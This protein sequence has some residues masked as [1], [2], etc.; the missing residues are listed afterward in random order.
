MAE[1]YT[2]TIFE[3]LSLILA[4]FACVVG[5][6]TML[7]PFFSEKKIPVESLYWFLFA[8]VAVLF[9]Y[10]KEITFMDLKIALQG[11]TDATKGLE[12][13]K[14][15]LEHAKEMIDPTRV[16]LIRGYQSYLRG[17]SEKERLEKVQL[18]TSLYSRCLRLT[19]EN[20]K[21]ML[22]REGYY[23]GKLDNEFT[24]EYYQAVC[25]FQRD[26]GLN[27]DGIFGYQSYRNLMDKTIS[28]SGYSGKSASH[29]NS[30]ENPYT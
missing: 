21:T 4:A 11:I 23:K 29:A 10:V 12:E 7:V 6:G 28:S 14:M 9:P 1:K 17:L 3:K 5:L 15:S 13:A 8:L 27:P 30:R 16:E 25:E 24:P 18:M 20:I 19:I 2:R 26:T 22:N